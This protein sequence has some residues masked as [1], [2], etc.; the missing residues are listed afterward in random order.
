MSA[1]IPF[2]PKLN[3]RYATRCRCARCDRLVDCREIKVAR[4]RP[5]LCA[6]CDAELT[7][8][9]SLATFA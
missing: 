5:Q 1:R 9:Y 4:G 3:T 2:Q 7:A 8:V 6:T